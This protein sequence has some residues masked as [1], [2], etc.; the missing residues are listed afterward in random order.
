MNRLLALAMLL[1]AGSL[2]ALPHVKTEAHVAAYAVVMGLAGG[3][4]IVI[5][6]AFWSAAYGRAHLGNI[7]GAAQALTVIASAV[8][9][10]LL[11]ECVTRTGSYATVFYALA[12]VVLL[13]A[14]NAWLLKPV[15]RP[16]HATG[17]SL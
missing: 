16:N 12:F 14:V 15:V 4:V 7:Q 9:P 8:G 5:F 6:F 2:L 10:L 11:A 3:F 17:S 1:L 13:L